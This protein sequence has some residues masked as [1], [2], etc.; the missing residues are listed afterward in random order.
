MRKILSTNLGNEREFMRMIDFDIN[1]FV[2]SFNENFF[3]ERKRAEREMIKSLLQTKSNRLSFVKS[4]S[5]KQLTELS[6]A[7]YDK[8]RNKIPNDITGALE[9]KAEKA[10]QNFLSDILKPTLRTAVKR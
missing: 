2:Y 9:G 5:T 1:G 3:K 8:T 6:E 4:D 10:G 7:M